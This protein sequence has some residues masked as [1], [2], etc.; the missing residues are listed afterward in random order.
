[1]HYKIKDSYVQFGLPGI[2][3]STLFQFVEFVKPVKFITLTFVIDEQKR[4][5]FATRQE[6]GEQLVLPL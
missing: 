5:P 3:D 1:V 6:P 4:G 2:S